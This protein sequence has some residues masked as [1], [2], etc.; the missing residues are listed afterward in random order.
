MVNLKK[1][2]SPLNK[3]LAR[4][5]IL[6]KFV[7]SLSTLFTLVYC[8]VHTYNKRSVPNAHEGW[9][10]LYSLFVMFSN[11]NIVDELKLTRCDIFEQTS[12]NMYV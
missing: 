4:K 6:K 11:V 8:T 2:P 1:D 10:S 3:S 7:L 12:T 9:R 5:C